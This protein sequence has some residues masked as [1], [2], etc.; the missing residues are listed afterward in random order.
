MAAETAVF[1]IAVGVVG[2]AWNAVAGGA[3]LFTFPALM[4]TG[5]PPI[6]A[7][8]TNYVAMLPSNA[9]ALPAFRTELRRIGRALVPLVV[10]TGGG[11]TVGSLLLLW[12]EPDV[13]VALVP[14]LLLVATALFAFGERVRQWVLTRISADASRFVLFGVLFFASIYGGYFGAGLGI[15]LLALAQVM[16]FSDFH[17]AN[18]IKNLL[19]TSF[20][21]LSIAIFGVGGLVAWPE[22]LTMMAGS[23]L[24]GFLG[25]RLSKR[26]NQILLHQLVILFG[27]ILTLVYAVRFWL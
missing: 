4:L 14:A 1:L 9:A 23:T 5:L 2:G 27:L 19:A 24:G 13:F 16:G 8:A 20:T 25:G 6:V 12:S 3:T 10:V 18:A 17:D 22:A 26:V 21:L 11:A 15:V 7:N